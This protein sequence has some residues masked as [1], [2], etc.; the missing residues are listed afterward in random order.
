MLYETPPWFFGF[1]IAFE[2]VFAAITLAVSLQSWRVFKLTR[3]RMPKLFGTGFLLIS[4]SYLVWAFVNL[5]IALKLDDASCAFCLGLQVAL[6]D[7]IGIFL[8]LLFFLAGV[9]VLTYNTL[10]IKSAPTL[11]LLLILTLGWLVLTI[12]K[13]WVFYILTSILFIFIVSYYLQRFLDRRSWKTFSIFLAF[14]LL[15]LGTLQ[16]IFLSV[17]TVYYAAGHVLELVAYI[18]ILVELIRVLKK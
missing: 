11:T 16:F 4:V 5:T 10:R 7:R 8:H 17:N 13:L 2:L 3:Q 18:L 14:V 9:V 6:L 15:F 12:Q 1:D